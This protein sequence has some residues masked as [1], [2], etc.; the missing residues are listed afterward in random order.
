MKKKLREL[1]KLS[2][3]LTIFYTKKN[4][5]M[6]AATAASLDMDERTDS[7][8]VQLIQIIYLEVDKIEKLSI[9]SFSITT[10]L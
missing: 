5:R 7:I 10:S 9:K 1:H 6:F 4:E 3:D 2:L 8:N